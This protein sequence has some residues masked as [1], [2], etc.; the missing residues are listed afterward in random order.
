[1]SYEDTFQIFSEAQVESLRK[2]GA[3]L[4]DCLKH[5]A[6]LVKPGITTMDL[7]REAEKFITGRGGKPAFKG[8]RGFPGT[9]CTSV[10]NAVVHGIPSA[11]EVLKEGDIISLDGG[12][13]LNGLYTDACVTVGVGAISND[14]QTFLT[15]VSQTLED[16]VAEVVK[17][18]AQVGDISSFIEQRLRKGGYKA[19]RVLTGHGLGDTLHQFPDVP[20]VGK[21][22]TGPKLPVGTMIAIEPIAVIGEAEVMTGPDQWTIFTK[23]KSLAC[24]FEHSVLITEGGC[25]VIA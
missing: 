15:H 7:D 8:Y 1:M 3:I 24:H 11:A 18:G 5:I 14:A 19:V 4:R 23:D 9:L 12:V 10:N 20:N 22:G 2:G 17:A 6:S 25:E 16:V 13:I 21:A